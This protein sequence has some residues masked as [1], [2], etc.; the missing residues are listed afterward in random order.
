LALNTSEPYDKP[1]KT[2]EELLQLME[3]RHIIIEDRE[4]AIR[5]LENLSYY[6]L[7]NGYKNIFS[8]FTDSD[9]FI[10]GTRFEELYTLH[11]IDTSLNNIIFKYILFLER[12]LKSRISYLVSK[13]YGVYTDYNDLTCCNPD[14]YLCAKYYSNSSGRRINVLKKIKQNISVPRHNPIIL[15][16]LHQKN[17]VPPWIVTTNIAYGLTIQW[18]N[19]L[20]AT[21]KQKICDTFID[22]NLCTSEKAKEFVKKALEITKE[23]RN[24]IAHGR[25]TF[26]F[27]S[28]P[29]LPKEQLLFLSF[30][31][32]SE[33]EYD[34]K[35]GQNDTM[36]VL[37]ALIIMINDTYLVSNLVRELVELFNPYIDITFNHKTV[38]EVFGFPNDLNQRLE[39]LALYKTIQ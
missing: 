23:Y 13:Q 29:Q 9:D 39:K 4:F 32:V 37:L 6:E 21:D 26:S 33:R 38:F 1:F 28:L 14:D 11:I 22:P 17:H 15:H 7:V 5:A 24:K 10:Q 35:M 12:A 27:D 3:S 20:K 8:A 36:A 31:A 16:Y 18:Y 34:S 19:I 2:Y 30:N 25:R